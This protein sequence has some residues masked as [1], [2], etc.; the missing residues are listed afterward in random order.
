M[1]KM[2]YLTVVL[3]LFAASAYGQ[4]IN[5]CYNKRTGDLRISSKCK[6]TEAPISWNVPG[7]AG[8]K[9]D[10]GPQGPPGGF[11]QVYDD[12][13]QIL[14][15]LINYAQNKYDITVLLDRVSGKMFTVRNLLYQAGSGQGVDFLFQNP[16][17]SGIPLVSID[18]LTSYLAADLWAVTHN[19]KFYSPINDT[20]TGLDS[21]IPTYRILDGDTQCLFI[22]K[23]DVQACQVEEV[24][25]GFTLPITLP[26]RFE[27]PK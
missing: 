18:Y 17:C 6:K 15:I 13:G 21:N 9:G 7:A 4:T 24:T 2:L 3:V 5:A 10:M 16:T 14:G 1:K 23:S 26:L 8:P 19:G 12:S 20:I 25:M 11:I 27:L 22:G